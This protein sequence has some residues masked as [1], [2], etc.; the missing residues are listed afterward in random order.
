MKLR[1]LLAKLARA[2]SLPDLRAMQP[3]DDTA[4]DKARKQPLAC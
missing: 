3:G 4:W 2:V 1:L